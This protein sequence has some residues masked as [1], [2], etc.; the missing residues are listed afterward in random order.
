MTVPLYLTLEEVVERYR[1]QIS[2]GILRNWRSKR[3]GPSFI[4]VG[5]AI[6]YPRDELDRWDRSN[7]VLCQRTLN[8][9]LDADD[10]VSDG[11]QEA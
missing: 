6:P 9:P 1:N 11:K 4:K 5:K 8:L 10:V 2:H 3:I 7:L